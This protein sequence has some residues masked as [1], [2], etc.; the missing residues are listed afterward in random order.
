M[1]TGWQQSAGSWYYFNPDPAYGVEG[2]MM[3]NMWL[4]G[5][6]GVSRY[7]LKDNGIMAQGWVDIGGNSYYFYPNNGV[8]AVNTVIDGTFR[9]GADGAWIH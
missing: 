7:Y 4:L 9:V 1:Q 8:L 5:T 2:A 6:D 3:K